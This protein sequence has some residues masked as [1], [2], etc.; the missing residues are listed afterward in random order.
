MVTQTNPLEELNQAFDD[1]RKG[2]NSKGVLLIEWT[3]IA[4]EISNP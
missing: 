3:N 2:A 1:M 4:N